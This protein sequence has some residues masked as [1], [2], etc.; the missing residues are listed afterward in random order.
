MNGNIS[1]SFERVL[2]YR[3]DRSAASREKSYC[4]SPNFL[5]ETMKSALEALT[6]EFE[7]LTAAAKEATLSQ[8]QAG[9][10][11]GMK[12]AIEVLRGRS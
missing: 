11:A 1:R 8:Y 3:D 10:I 7:A 12:N 2:F 4:S 5:T 6:I 9:Y